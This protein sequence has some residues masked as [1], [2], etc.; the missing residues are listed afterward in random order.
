MNFDENSNKKK[1]KNVNSHKKKVQTKTSI[2]VFRIILALIFI[3]GFSILGAGIGVYVGIVERAPELDTISVSPSIHTSI[4][5]AEDT[6]EEIARL[7]GSENRIYVKLEELPEYVGL[8]A[9]AIE[10]ERFYSHNGVD[11]KSLVR[12]VYQTLFG[13]FKQG[14]STITQQLIKNSLGI[15]NNTIVTK[16]QEQFLA[17]QYEENLAEDLGSKKLAKDYILEL[18]LNTVAFGNNLNGVQTA[19]NYY[20]EKEAKDLSISESAII[21][22]ITQFP[23]RNAPNTEEG[24]EYNYVRAKT[25]VDYMFK[26]GF[27]SE[28]EYNEAVADLSGPA[29][30]RIKQ[31]RQV[32]EEAASSNSYFVDQIINELVDDFMDQGFTEAKSYDLI[33]SG[34]LEIYATINLE[35]QEVLDNVML[36]DS[37]FNANDYRIEVHYYFSVEDNTTKT[38][39]HFEKTA[40]LKNQ[41]AV[42]EYIAAT[43]AE[44]EA[45]GKTVFNEE[46]V[47][48]PQPQAAFTIMDQTTGK[49]IA[50][51]GGRGEKKENRV[52]NR[53]TQSIRQQG[54]V[55]KIVAAYLPAI[56]IGVATAATVLDDVPYYYDDGTTSGEFVN[57]YK[58]GYRGLSTVR[59][60]IR[61][62]MNIIAV[63]TMELVGIDTS[64]SYMENLGFSTLT[65][66]DK[67]LSTA[68]GGITDGVSNIETTAAFATIANDGVY[69][70]PIFYSKVYNH[71][72]HLIIDNMPEEKRVIKE[73]SA[74]I[75]T[76][77]MYDVVYGGGTGAATRFSNGMA[78]AGKTGTTTAKKDLSYYGYT[79]YLTAGI[80]MG[81]DNST[82]MASSSEE[83]KRIWSKVMEEVHNVM[84]YEV[85]TSFPSNSSVQTAS[86][87][88]ESGELAGELCSLDP[89]GSRVATEYFVKGTVPTTTCSVH[90]QVVID[91]TTG[92]IANRFCP[93]ESQETIV[94]IIRPIPY[95]GDAYVVDAQ[96]E[97]NQNNVCTDHTAETVEATIIDGDGQ[98]V[99]TD[100]EP[101]DG[102]NG[103]TTTE[104]GTGT[105]NK[106]NNKNNNNSNTGDSNNSNSNTG[107]TG[108]TNNSNNSNTTKPIEEPIIEDIPPYVE[109]GGF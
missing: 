80:W 73:E 58:D 64:F 21:V 14:G 62:S 28:S 40:L 43:K 59:E 106:S 75:L 60:G 107:T 92:K 46:V 15:S 70:E 57:W 105:E 96:Y 34:G 30:E 68:L 50:I 79:P 23:V 10:D 29:Y 74:W 77:M 38:V 47:K 95:T 63:R 52:L 81:Y 71:E 18:Y 103:D 72:G 2:M 53:A 11:L 37:M 31:S 27:I 102:E 78:V 9:V 13:D 22:S 39:E 61:D 82:A 32:V 19:A 108:S 4:I 93:T 8:A 109:G 6:G 85:V 49:V 91:T 101:I 98:E 36:D 1:M 5:Y 86:I 89:R 84:G 67:N 55:F 41:E 76:D 35:A 25:T 65:D 42:D 51:S 104:T 12:M 83:H 24:A 66:N 90:S 44:Y 56:D 100:G 48:I 97:I 45:A 94:G 7:V 54:S 20:F 88:L 3:L 26:L 16:L 87:C 17:V 33:Y 99:E 69:N